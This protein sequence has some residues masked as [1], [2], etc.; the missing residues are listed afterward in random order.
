MVSDVTSTGIDFLADDSAHYGQWA[1]IDALIDVLSPNYITANPTKAAVNASG[2]LS[3]DLVSTAEMVNGAYGQTLLS[4]VGF[5]A[6]NYPNVASISITDLPITWDGYGAD[7]LALY[8]PLP[9]GRIGR[10]IRMDRSILTIL[11]LATGVRQ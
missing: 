10:A 3:T 6:A 1:Q 7:D 4:M 11:P 9:A 8:K 5:I 2:Q